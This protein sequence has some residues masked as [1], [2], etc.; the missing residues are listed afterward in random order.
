MTTFNG[1]LINKIIAHLTNSE[2]CTVETS[3]Y[4]LDGIKAILRD[5]FGFRYEVHVKTLSRIDD[6]PDG[7]DALNYKLNSV[8]LNQTNETFN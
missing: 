5:A 6:R 8:D 1:W 3:E 7:L 4:T 2:G